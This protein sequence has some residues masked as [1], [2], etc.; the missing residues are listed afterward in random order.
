M[1]IK[2]IVVSVGDCVVSEF[3]NVESYYNVVIPVVVSP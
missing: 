1:T 2:V 3:T